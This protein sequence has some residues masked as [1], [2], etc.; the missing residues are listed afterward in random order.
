VVGRRWKRA[1]FRGQDSGFRRQKSGGQVAEERGRGQFYSIVNHGLWIVSCLLT[2][3][4]RRLPTV[5]RLL[6]LSE[7][8]R[9]GVFEGLAG[10]PGEVTS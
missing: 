10:G 2:S 3:R 5:Y 6:P 7:A 1:G 8:G 4:H 9:R